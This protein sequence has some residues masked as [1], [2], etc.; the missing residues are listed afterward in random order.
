MPAVRRPEGKVG[1]FDAG[2][3]MRALKVRL[4]KPCPPW[5]SLSSRSSTRRV[6][7]R[8]ESHRTAADP[9][10]CELRIRLDGPPTVPQASCVSSVTRNGLWALPSPCAF[11]STTEIRSLGTCSPSSTD[12]ARGPLERAILCSQVAVTGTARG[13]GRAAVGLGEANP[14]TVTDVARRLG[15]KR[16]TDH[17][18]L[19]ICPSH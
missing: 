3:R 1:G 5:G 17:E 15:S 10:R 18:T 2:Q 11:P 14:L 6:M 12:L 4:V 7:V 9:W 13:Q 16:Y 8:T 19:P